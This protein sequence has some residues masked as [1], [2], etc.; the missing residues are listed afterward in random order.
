MD[1]PTFLVELAKITFA[2]IGT[3]I[4]GV[5]LWLKLGRHKS[6]LL[7]MPIAGLLTLGIKNEL[8]L[9]T[10]FTPEVIG[11]VLMAHIAVT[12]LIAALIYPSTKARLQKQA[13]ENSSKKTHT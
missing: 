6:L 13:E 1:I 5:P 9:V 7:T 8:P 4:I 10:G 3:L 2:F 12:G 11:S